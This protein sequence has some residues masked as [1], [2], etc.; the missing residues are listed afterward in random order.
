[1]DEAVAAALPDA[2]AE[3]NAFDSDSP[4][5]PDENEE[6]SFISEQRAA[7]IPLV[8][9]SPKLA[10]ENELDRQPLPKLD[11]LIARIPANVQ[12]VLEDL[13]RAK[14]NA[15]RRVPVAALKKVE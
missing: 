9:S 5:W 8:A 1:M 13:F 11:D 12:Q 10:E 4:R 2:S 14:F 7:G 6:S 15:V 3:G